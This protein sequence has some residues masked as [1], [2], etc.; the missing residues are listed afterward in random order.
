MA[1]SKVSSATDNYKFYVCVF[2]DQIAGLLINYGISNT[3]E[4]EIP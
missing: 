1:F 2:K 3:V 4:L